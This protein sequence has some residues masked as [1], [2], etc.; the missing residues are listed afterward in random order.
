MTGKH[1][2]RGF[3]LIEA[4]IVLAVVGLVLGGIWTAAAKFY[5]DYKVNNTVDGILMIVRNTQNLI[6]FATAET[7]GNSQNIT[8]TLIK[9]RVFPKNWENGNALLI[10]N[11][12]GGNTLVMNHASNFAVRL[13]EIPP[14]ACVKLT[15]KISSIGAMM[16]SRGDGLYAR[17]SLG[18]ISSSGS[19]S[20]LYISNFPA[21]LTAAKAFCGNTKASMEFGYNYPRT[22]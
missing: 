18:F 3:S 5:E 17:S 14:S 20:P 10:T 16:G 2:Q 4:A 7:I 19:G 1:K 21:S 13:Y 11:P 6:N 22:N 8:P 15:I 12:F 9:A